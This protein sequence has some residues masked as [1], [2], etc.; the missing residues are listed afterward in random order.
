MQI[1]PLLKLFSVR[2]NCGWLRKYCLAVCM[3]CVVLE[4]KIWTWKDKNVMNN[5]SINYSL[6]ISILVAPPLAIKMCREIISRCET[7]VESLFFVMCSKR[8]SGYKYFAVNYNQ[9]FFFGYYILTNNGKS[10]AG[11]ELFMGKEGY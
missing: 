10:T 1:R 7:K 4:F 3:H 9:N 5:W 8:C 6:E 2:I 11:I